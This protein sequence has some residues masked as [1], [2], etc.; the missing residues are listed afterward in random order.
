MT[1][2]PSG[3]ALR[4]PTASAVDR[5]SNAI[6]NQSPSDWTALH[7]DAAFDA[8]A[9]V[10]VRIPQRLHANRSATAV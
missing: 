9:L 1:A 5:H 4:R 7:A 6:T 8:P 3:A 10:M 2:V